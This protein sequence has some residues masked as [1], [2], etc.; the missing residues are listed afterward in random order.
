M[1]YGKIKFFDEVKNFGFIVDESGVNWFFGRNNLLEAFIE[2]GQSVEFE[3]GKNQRGVC[4]TNI[5]KTAF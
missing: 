4:A 2:K 3:E 1:M 5:C